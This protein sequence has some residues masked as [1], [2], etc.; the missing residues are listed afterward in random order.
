[1]LRREFIVLLGGAVVVQSH[2]AHGEK[3]AIPVIGYLGVAS[4]T[5]NRPYTAAF[6]NG[7]EQSGF[8]DGQML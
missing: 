5:S 6:F 4:E 2:T 7:L 1:M 3:S 8:H